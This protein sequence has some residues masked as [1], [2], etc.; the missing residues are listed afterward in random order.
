MTID[1]NFR[2]L[3]SL[4]LRRFCTFIIKST[5]SFRGG[6]TRALCSSYSDSFLS[7]TPILLFFSFFM[8]ANIV[9][10]PH[11]VI[12]LF[13][14]RRCFLP[15]LSTS[16][17]FA[18]CTGRA[19]HDIKIRKI[20]TTKCPRT[21]YAGEFMSAGEE[22]DFL[23]KTRMH[24]ASFKHRMLHKT[25]ACENLCFGEHIE[26]LLYDEFCSPKINKPIRHNGDSFFCERVFEILHTAHCIQIF[27]KSSSVWILFVI[28]W[29]D[30][31][32][33]NRLFF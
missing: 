7:R 25:N 8:S 13:L 31:L 23:E 3:L 30:C 11:S 19:D 27:K 32:L 28:F 20:K 29:C 16:H 10:I 9:L 2:E 22:G 14:R 12:F 21:Q 33:A 15:P 1:K 24:D 5:K 17:I 18:L 26:K 6:K 4:F